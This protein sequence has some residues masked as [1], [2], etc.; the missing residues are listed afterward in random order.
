ME[1]RHNIPGML[2]I[3]VM[4]ALAFALIAAAY[5]HDDDRPAAK[6]PPAQPSKTV[7]V[8][9]V[10]LPPP[11]AAGRKVL[12]PSAAERVNP[13]PRLAPPSIAAPEAPP[14][15]VTP[16]DPATESD[17][18]TL[19][20]LLEF[21]KG[22]SITIAWPA[23]GNARTRLYQIFTRCLGMRTALLDARGRLYTSDQAPGRNW[24][25]N[26]DRFSSFMRRPSGVLSDAENREIMAI[27]KHHSLTEGT[28][29]R[30]FPRRVDAV[31][32]GGLKRI[33]GDRYET[34]ANITAA[35]RLNG[36]D[37]M[38]DNVRVNGDKSKRGIIPL[39]DRRCSR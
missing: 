29:V 14:A 39:S 12:R 15:D 7:A 6:V 32:L 31:L 22:P 25:P 3:V 16:D 27:Q 17:D 34:D 30:L 4:S 21:G 18:R 9:A 11:P 28:P 1:R 5:R 35:Y 37:V 2:S 26:L 19:L 36:S 10:I 33:V 13:K 24:R 38:V 20:R 8:T 23:G